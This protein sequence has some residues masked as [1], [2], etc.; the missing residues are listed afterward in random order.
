[1]KLGCNKKPILNRTLDKQCYLLQYELNHSL[2]NFNEPIAL[3]NLSG[4]NPL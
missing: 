3:V 4:I 1:M 2:L